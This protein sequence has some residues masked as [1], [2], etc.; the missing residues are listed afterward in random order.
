MTA[1]SP[2]SKDENEWR[3]K[4][5]KKTKTKWYVCRYKGVYGEGKTGRLCMLSHPIP[6]NLW[7]TLAYLRI[8]DISFK[9]DL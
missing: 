6:A 5:R 1:S 3:Q 9:Q 4:R 2:P 8:P 7:E